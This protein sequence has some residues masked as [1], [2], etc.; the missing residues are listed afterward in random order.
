VAIEIENGIPMPSKRRK[1]Y[2]FAELEVGQ[3]FVAEDV[4]IT[5]ICA[6]FKNYR[7]KQFTARTI[8]GGVRVWRVE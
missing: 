1:K 4:K 8:D 3:S 7:P 2:P 5:C 6:S